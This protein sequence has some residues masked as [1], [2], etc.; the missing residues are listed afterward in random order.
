[1]LNRL[2]GMPA[3]ARGIAALTVVMV[4]FFVLAMV[5]AYTNRTLIV[6]QR[7]TT[8]ALR[9]AQALDV[10]EAGTEWAI[11]QINSGRLSSTCGS[12]TVD[13]DSTLRARY[14]ELQGDYS[15]KPA[16]G[17]PA[18]PMACVSNLGTWVCSCPKLGAKPTLAPTADGNGQAFWVE[19]NVGISKPGVVPIV[20]QG[21]SNLGSDASANCATARKLVAIITNV[22][23]IR[24]STTDLGLLRA[25]PFAPAAALTAGTTVTAAAGTTLWVVNP[26]PS[27]GLTIHSGGAVTAASLKLAV[28]A[29]SPGDGKL[30]SDA[31]L[32]KRAAEGGRQFE[33]I[34]GMDAVN[35]RRQ[36]ATVMIDC[37][38]GC[39]SI[40]LTDALAR[41]PGQVLWIAGDLNLNSAATLGSASQPVMMVSTGTVTFSS[42]INFNGFLYANA[43]VWDT[44]AAAA[45]LRGAMVSATSF[46][47]NEN[48]TMLYD[49]SIINIIKGS[50]GSFVRAPGGT[51]Y[52]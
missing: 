14:I 3:P 45:V 15:Y 49:A 29:G 43:V 5:A 28:A 13:T 1:M 23:A 34:F 2:G 12:S 16:G 41:H 22:D 44:G 8:N 4:L 31:A 35:Y 20:T 26:D 17:G 32:A 42:T 40:D 38:A 33:S 36:P 47:S 39:K 19:F 6:D 7:S 30:E 46:V 11:A 51:T 27:T 25:L 21:C 18:T 52:Y 10:I 50:Y 24:A 9:S 37:A 48:A